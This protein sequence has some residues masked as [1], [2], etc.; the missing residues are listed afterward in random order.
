MRSMGAKALDFP[1][2]SCQTYVYIWHAKKKNR[3]QLKSASVDW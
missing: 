2:L 1:I 3:Y